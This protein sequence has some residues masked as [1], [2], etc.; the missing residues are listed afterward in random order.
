[1]Q[2]SEPSKLKV[3][4]AFAA[5]YIIWG[6]TYFFIREALDGFPPFML[7]GLRFIAATT[8]MFGWCLATGQSIHPGRDL[9]KAVIVGILLCFV[10]NGVVVWVEQVLPSSVVAIMIAVAPLS[11]VVL[12]K[13]NWSVNF[14]SPATV[15]GVLAGFAGVLLLF[16]EKIQAQLASPD[17]SPEFS[18]MLVL[19]IGVVA[20]PAG[21]IYA[22]YNPGTIP[23]MVN[24]G[25]QML[26]GGVC[27]M[28][29]SVTRGEW[30]TMD[31]GAVP[32]SAWLSITYLMVFGS[33]IAFSAYVWLL[34]IRPAT[35][36]ST[37]AYVNPVVAVLLGVF[38]GEEHINAR[39][40]G[41]LVVI[42]G[43]VLM[44]NLAK[45]RSASRAQ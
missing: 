38:A 41:G 15:L 33:V 36:V 18:A 29:V 4:L 31:W 27:F 20:W 17:L 1:M 13:P 16:S 23:N 45:Y 42:L 12:D 6:S 37:Y 43:S 3:V 11:F 8:V 32:G 2:G 35:Q 21:S 40:I 7:G 26:A 9:K 19:L 39:E 24:S 14:R 34:R 10:G 25:W 28:A 5:I 22:K 30:T 44:I